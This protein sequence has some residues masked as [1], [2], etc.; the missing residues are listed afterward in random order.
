[1]SERAKLRVFLDSNVLFSG[2]Y[3]GEGPSGKILELY[4]RGAIS[5][6]VSRQVLEEFVR[7]VRTKLPRALPT[8]ERLLTSVPPEVVADPPEEQVM[9]A[10]DVINVM[11]APVLAA[12]A[13]AEPDFFVTGDSGYFQDNPEVVRFGGFPV[14]TPAQFMGYF[15]VRAE[16]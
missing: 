15:S 13:L 10:C 6:V 2:L 5:V 7:T 12:D 11:D 3:S 16:T 8:L 14:V 9:Q 1:M 4:V